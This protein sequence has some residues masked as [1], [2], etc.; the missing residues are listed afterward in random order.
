MEESEVCFGCTGSF[1]KVLRGKR[2]VPGP[3]A[4][5]A[6]DWPSVGRP[7]WGQTRGQH[8]CHLEA[9]PGLV[10]AAEM[11]ERVGVRMDVSAVGAR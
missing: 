3:R 9:P 8:P 11:E 10:Q 2:E 6:V 5:P 1:Q 7:P 4:A